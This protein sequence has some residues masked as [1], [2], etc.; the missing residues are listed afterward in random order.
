[1]TSYSAI[2]YNAKPSTSNLHHLFLR[3]T[4]VGSLLNWHFPQRCPA[5]SRP[6]SPDVSINL[7]RTLPCALVNA[8]KLCLEKSKE[9]LFSQNDLLSLT[10]SYRMFRK[11]QIWIDFEQLKMGI[12]SWRKLLLKTL[13]YPVASIFSQKIF[14]YRMSQ[15]SGDQSRIVEKGQLGKSFRAKMKTGVMMRQWF[16]I[17]L[18]NADLDAVVSCLKQVRT[19]P[20]ARKRAWCMQFPS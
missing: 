16:P 8:K 11:N 18:K 14:C 9:I 1:M 5:R 19:L 17:H 3:C 6:L 15:G 2:F 4:V 10:S 7:P 13:L 20:T 12:D